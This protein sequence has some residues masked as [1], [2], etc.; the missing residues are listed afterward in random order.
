MGNVVSAAAAAKADGRSSKGS[1]KA[2]LAHPSSVP[3]VPHLVR[4]RNLA[5]A[6]AAERAKTA[7]RSNH[8]RISG[9]TAIKAR[10]SAAMRLQP[11][12]RPRTRMVRV[13]RQQ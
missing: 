3:Q 1:S 9:R 11:R 13:A 8:D 10:R 6:D 5:V 7:T 4:A 2:S 12:H